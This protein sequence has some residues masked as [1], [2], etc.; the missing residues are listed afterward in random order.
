MTTT[1]VLV[2]QALSH[3]RAGADMVAPSDMM[4][5]RIGAIRDALEHEGFSNTQIMA[6]SAKTVLLWTFPG[7]SGVSGNLKGGDKNLSNGP[8]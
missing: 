6:Y 2:K 7:C 5:G 8:G 4:D 3:A 1:D